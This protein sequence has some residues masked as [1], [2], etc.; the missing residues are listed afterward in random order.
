MVVR[1]VYRSVTK[2]SSAPS[3][4]R[5]AAAN[6]SDA[7]AYTAACADYTMMCRS[8]AKVLHRRDLSGWYDR[9]DQ[10]WR[11]TNEHAP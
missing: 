8:I 11:S 7:N 6:G 5:A 3:I 1:A 2:T 10:E 4:D 9:C